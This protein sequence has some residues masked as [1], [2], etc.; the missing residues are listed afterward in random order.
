MLEGYSQYIN[1]VAFLLDGQLVASASGDSIMQLWETATGSCC[2]RPGGYFL[3]VN[4]VAF[5]PDGQLVASIL[6]DKTV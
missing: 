2:S 3:L 1:A 4:T 5:S 6:M